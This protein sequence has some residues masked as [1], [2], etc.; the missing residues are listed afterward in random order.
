MQRSI[1]TSVSINIHIGGLYMYVDG[2]TFL[3]EDKQVNDLYH[4]K[5]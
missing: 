2:R 3:T 1:G 5:K 4:R